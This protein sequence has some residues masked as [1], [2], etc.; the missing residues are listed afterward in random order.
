MS[1]LTSSPKC[2]PLEHQPRDFSANPRT[3]RSDRVRF[4]ALLRQPL[5]WSAPPRMTSSATAGAYHWSFH[6]PVPNMFFVT[7]ALSRIAREASFP[8]RPSYYRTATAR[9][10]RE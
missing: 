2:N 1:G 7:E 6:P 4:P 10:P 5:F 3:C 9:M 8:N